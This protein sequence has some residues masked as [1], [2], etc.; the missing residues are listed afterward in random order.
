MGSGQDFAV[1]RGDGTTL[2]FLRPSSKPNWYSQ[3]ED[4]RRRLE[5]IY[6]FAWWLEMG[7]NRV[8]EAVSGVLMR[9]TWTWASLVR[10]GMLVSRMLIEARLVLSR[11]PAIVVALLCT[12]VMPV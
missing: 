10:V 2:I 12:A 3:L 1:D 5:K 6:G 4:V 8:L 11:R 9:D 7:E